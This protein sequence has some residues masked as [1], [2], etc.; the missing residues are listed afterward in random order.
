MVHAAKSYKMLLAFF[1]APFNNILTVIVS[2]RRWNNIEFPPR[3]HSLLLN[4]TS[5]I[6]EIEIVKSIP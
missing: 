4:F 3:M 6:Q 1:F 2:R 5:A